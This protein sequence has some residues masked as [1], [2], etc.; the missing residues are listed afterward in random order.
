VLL[1]LFTAALVAVT[2]APVS[3][4]GLILLV[5]AV[6]CARI[7]WCGVI[8]LRAT[9]WRANFSRPARTTFV[10]RMQV[11]VALISAAVGAL[12][13]VVLDQR[14]MAFRLLF[15]CAAIFAIT[16]LVVFRRMRVRPGRQ[17]QKAAHNTAVYGEVHAQT[18]WQ[19]LR[20]D[21]KYRVFLIWLFV[22][23]SGT[24][25]GTAPL[26]LVLARE[27][28]VSS[29]T[30]VLITASVPTLMIPLTTPF[31]ARLLARR[32]AITY[33]A[34]NSYLFVGAAIIA[35]AGATNGWLALLWISAA[36]QGAA[37][38]GGM[39]VWALAHND[40]APP[41]LANEYLGIHVTLAGIRGALAPVL[42]AA[43]YSWLESRG[44]GLGSWALAAPLGLVT[45]GAIGFTRLERSA[46]HTPGD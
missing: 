2:V 31:W 21:R 8:T 1:G 46:A 41:G 34:L 45:V 29:I 43:L 20:E 37:A 17:L 28:A 38:A 12:A 16:G 35:L 32:H 26:I 24:L 7:L 22:L 13:G 33:R 15:A 42:G 14:P 10:A 6:V 40:F 44:P 36:L 27:L 11:T 30:Q 19:I 3:T 5:G 18:S 39:L 4:A 25:M 9:I 23:G